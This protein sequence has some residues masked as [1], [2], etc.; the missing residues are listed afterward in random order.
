MRRP[1]L[2][3]DHVQLRRGL[4]GRE[5]DQDVAVGGEPL[6]LV[7]RA[8]LPKPP[9]SATP[10]WC[11]SAAI[12]TEPTRPVAPA[13]TTRMISVLGATTPYSGAASAPSAGPR[14]LARRPVAEPRGRSA[15]TP[16]WALSRGARGAAGRASDHDPDPDSRR[17]VRHGRHRVRVAR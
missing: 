5:V 14:M 8:L 4:A 7:E 15:F 16:R 12:K 2:N 11:G 17:R 6:E 1:A 13:T 9:I 10:G 3:G